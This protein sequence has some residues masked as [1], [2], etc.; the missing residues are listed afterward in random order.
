[1]IV[2]IFTTVTSA[3][4]L[5]QKVEDDYYVELGMTSEYPA[6]S[7]REIYNKNPVGRND[8]GYYWIKSHG[9]TMKVM[10]INSQQVNVVLVYRCS[11]LYA[12]MHDG[13][14]TIIYRAVVGGP[15]GQAMAGLVLV[16]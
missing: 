5:I 6:E 7:C 10:H 3:S 2:F 9:A 13:Y 16:L 1:M 8:S 12:C 4:A 11:T 14:Y 15:A